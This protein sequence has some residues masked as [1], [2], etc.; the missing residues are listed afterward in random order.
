MVFKLG[1]EAQKALAPVLG[2]RTVELIPKVVT[3]VRFVDGDERTSEGAYSIIYESPRPDIAL[4]TLAPETDDVFT[5][6]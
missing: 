4:L 2:I 1:L 5:A 6:P 3:G